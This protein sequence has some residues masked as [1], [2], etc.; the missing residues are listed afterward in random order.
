MADHTRLGRQPGLFPLSGSETAHRTSHNSRA[1]ASDEVGR[2]SDSDDEYGSLG[3]DEGESQIIERLLQG[4]ASGPDPVGREDVPSG[5]EAEPDRQDSFRVTDIED[6]EPPRGIYLP[7]V[8]GLEQTRFIQNQEPGA[9]QLEIL[10][11]FETEGGKHNPAHASDGTD[12]DQR[13]AAIRNEPENGETREKSPS[14][15]PETQ[16]PQPDLRSPLERF[17]RPPKKAL[18]V[19]DLVSPAWC[20][21]QY[22]YTLSKHGRKRRTPAMKQGSKVHQELED[23]VHITVPIE[24][25][26]IEDSWGLR[27][28]NIIQ[29]LR[30]LRDTGRT[31]ELE[32][33]GTVGGEIVNGVIDELSYECPD[34]KLQETLDSRNGKKKVGPEL[35]EY[36]KTITEFMTSAAK[37]ENGQSISA[38]LSSTKEAAKP[39][40]KQEKQIYI[41]DVKTRNSPTLPTGS[42]TRPTILQLH[43]YH[44]MLENIA[45][46]NFTLVQLAERY[47]LNTNETFSDSFIAQVGNLNQNVFDAATSQGLE[48]VPSSQDSIDIL[49]QHNN[50]STLWDFMIS[51]FRLSFLLP[52]T[53]PDGS[54]PTST[55]QSVSD[56]PAPAAQPTRLS[57][58]L[59]AEYLAS[60]YRH[61]PGT[62]KKFLGKKSFVFNADFLKN[63]LEDSLAWWHGERD[64]KGVE[65]QEAW[66]CRGC[67]FR[68]DCEWLHE[69]DR[70]ALEK[71]LQRKA[72]RDAAGAKETKMDKEMGEEVRRSKV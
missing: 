7:K 24:V 51:Q 25:T 56:L 1:P 65:L 69:R 50:L 41:T 26:K 18:S 15:G 66:K 8:R 10:R 30:T 44:H 23:E 47:A 43:L 11:D 32:I 42:S 57:P 49:L 16:A 70:D 59:T 31:R 6:Y 39:A 53:G 67:D 5:P 36:Q 58:V 22:F 35:P 3:V 37:A 61:A 28:W 46:G 29:G 2:N 4:V 63:Y 17:R 71:V 34:P 72:L 13:L 27:I 48:D 55:P 38:A 20:E 54:I 19:T 21:L 52:S 60:N 64:A 14:V 68:D 12:T 33:W 62:S 45:Q 9:T 40:K